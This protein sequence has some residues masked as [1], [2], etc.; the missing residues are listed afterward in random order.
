MPQK[1]VIPKQDTRPPQTMQL[2]LPAHVAER[3]TKFAAS[4]GHT[5]SYVA[6][7]ILDGALPPEESAPEKKADAPKEK[8]PKETPAK[9]A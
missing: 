1:L 8:H 7:F 6:T 9:A 5:P 3:L 2:E 4:G